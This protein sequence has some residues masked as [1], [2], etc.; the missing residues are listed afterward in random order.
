M[1]HR[2]EFIMEQ[3]R[4]SLSYRG[5]RWQAMARE[6]KIRS[7]TVM[8]APPLRMLHRERGQNAQK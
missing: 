4:A 6:G 5:E 3:N 2:G 8:A 7:Q 1:E